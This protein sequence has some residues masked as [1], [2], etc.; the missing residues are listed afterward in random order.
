MSSASILVGFGILSPIG[1][2]GLAIPIALAVP[3]VGR[4]CGIAVF[5]ESAQL[6]VMVA[7]LPMSDADMVTRSEFC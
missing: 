3:K 5:I 6:N 4:S 7:P 1:K 2:S